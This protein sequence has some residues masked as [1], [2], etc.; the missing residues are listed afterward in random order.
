LPRELDEQVSVRGGSLDA[1]ARQQ[2]DALDPL[3]M[4]RYNEL[5]ITTRRLG[6]T[7]ADTRARVTAVDRAV[8]RLEGLSR[9]KGRLDEDMQVAVQRARLLSVSELTGRFERTV[10]QTARTLDK[11]VAF[12]VRGDALKLDKVLLDA[13]IEPLMH[14]LRNAVDH[15]IEASEQRS[16]VGKPSSGSLTLAFQQIQQTLKITLNDDGGGLDYARIAAR[17]VR[18]GV[19]DDDGAS[20]AHREFLHSLLFLPG[21]ST[22][23]EVSQTS[24]RGVGLDVVAAR[25]QRLGGTIEIQS[26]TGRGTRFELSV[27][28]ALGTLQV[29]LVDFGAHRLALA[30]DSFLR[31]VPLDASEQ[32]IHPDGIDVAVDGQ[33]LPAIDGG[34]LLDLDPVIASSALE[35]RVGLLVEI[36][37]EGLRVVLVAAIVGLV[38]VVLKSFDSLIKPIRGVR[39]GTVLGDGRAAA[40]IDLR[41][42]IRAQRDPLKFTVDNEVAIELAARVVVADDSLSVRRALGELLEDSGYAPELARDGLEALLAIERKAPRALLVDLEMPRMN[43]LELTAHLRR[44]PKFQTLPIIMITSR[45]AETHVQLARDAGVTEVLS[46]PYSDEELLTILGAALDNAAAI[47]E[48]RSV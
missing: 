16:A 4:E 35:S 27:P 42:R 31:F 30:A 2:P 38:T 25:I 1:L 34:R 3:E 22:R 36:P 17:A 46:K 23:E 28:L 33:W 13:L 39:G 11:S 15:G 41:E 5:Y 43:G 6:E 40:V 20:E 18:M 8:A 24:G 14:L 19:L 12:E 48:A 29:A 32:R 7:H 44:D 45:T 10:R 26:E 9:R 21:F 37:G 47:E